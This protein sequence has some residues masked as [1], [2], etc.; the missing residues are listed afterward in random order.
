MHCRDGD[1]T[2]FWTAWSRAVE[3]SWFSVIALGRCWDKS[4]KGRGHCKI[5]E[6]KCKVKDHGQENAEYYIGK[7]MG[8]NA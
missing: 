5:I 7:Y 4:L 1:M 2:R 3:N 6:V 8:K